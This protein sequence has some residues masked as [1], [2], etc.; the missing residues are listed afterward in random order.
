[1]R[2]PTKVTNAQGHEKPRCLEDAQEVG[3]AH[4]TDEIHESVWREGANV[5]VAF[6]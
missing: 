4:S 6:E 1:M 3:L 5:K 2:V